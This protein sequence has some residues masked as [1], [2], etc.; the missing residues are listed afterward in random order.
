MMDKAD[1]K[2]APESS[3][4]LD[5][6][7]VVELATV[8]AGPGAGRYLADYGAEVIKV[9]GPGG[10]PTRRMGW[11]G[12]GEAD[13][14]FWKLVN[15]NKQVISLDLKT[16]Q[17]RETLWSLL[18]EADVLIENMRP[19]KLEAL[20]FMPLE[21]MRRNPKLV[22][23][24]VTGF[25]QDGPY[26]MHP[27]FATIAEA[28]SGFSNLLGEAGGPP[29]LP[30]VALTDEV[31]ALVGAFATLVALRH[32]ERTG[33]GQVV[34]VNLLTSMFQIMGPLPS[35]YAHM[36]YLQPRLGS[37]IP[38]TVPRG[39]YRCADGVWVAISSSADSIAK[40]VLELV[41]LGDDELFATFQARSKNREALEVHVADW[42]AARPSTEVLREFRRV[43][44][45]IAKVLDMKDIFADEHYRARHMITE[46][47][48]VAM[49]NVVAGLSKTPG[50]VRHAGRAFDADTSAVIDRLSKVKPKTRA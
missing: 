8:V 30:P 16:E 49:Q 41:G 24:R 4:P 27:G 9:E 31:T 14:Y 7:R 10:D 50:R 46:A 26:A 34:D 20:G 40:R 33:E 5:G 3:G 12:P 44:A 38:Y 36:G 35:A 23:L 37:G 15:R 11:T 47:D 2:P 45:A 22:V 19:G 32:A 29:L 42:V 21:L 28:M 39:T 1:P 18:A 17:G 6:I 25:G 48:G 13:S 43:D